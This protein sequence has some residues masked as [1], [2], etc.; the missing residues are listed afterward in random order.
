LTSYGVTATGF[1]RKTLTDLIDGIKAAERA[2]ISSTLNLLATSVLGQLNGIFADRL[3][4]VWG[5][6]EAV[7]RSMYPDS[8][9]DEALDQVCS[10]TG[11]TRLPAT[12][13]TVTLDQMYLEDGVTVPPGS[14]VS[15]GSA[16][17]R[18][19]TLTQAKNDTGFQATFSVDAESEDKGPIVGSAKTIDTIQTPIS[20]WLDTPGVTCAVAEDYALDGLRLTVELENGVAQDFDF[21]A[22]NPW[23]ASD[24][25]TLI[26]ATKTGLTVIDA[27]GYVRIL[28]DASQGSVLISGTANTVLQF[29]AYVIK[30]FNEADTHVGRLL[31]TDPDLRARRER[32]LRALGSGTVEAIRARL[33]EVADIIQAFVVENDADVCST[34]GLPPHS[35]EAIVED[36]ADADIAQVIWDNGPIGISSY[37][38][39]SETVTDSQGF[40]HAIKFSRPTPVR[41]Y[42]IVEVT[43]NADFPADGIQQVKDALAAYGDLVQIG[44]DLVALRFHSVP[45]SVAG[46]IDIPTF[47]MDIVDPPVSTANVSIAYRDIATF[48]TADIDVTVTP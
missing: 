44:E 41:I 40:T 42:M 10:Y 39:E 24:V 45:F 43:T 6:A 16:G 3:S 30:G 34:E 14:V 8:A 7:Y 20:G 22:G 21:A 13:S 46:V 1:V 18:F 19:V 25:K 33:L 48:D 17:A 9:S 11:V 26:D 37:G 5:L 12:P 35:F 2:T 23:S 32:L 29:P 36:G 28:T 4:E 15:V 47:L 38:A 27:G 31:E